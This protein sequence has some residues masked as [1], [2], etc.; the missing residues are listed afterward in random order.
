MPSPS[1]E[2]Q[3]KQQ[4]QENTNII[5]FIFNITN[6]QATATSQTRDHCRSGRIS[7]YLGMI[8]QQLQIEAA[9][10]IS[11]DKCHSFQQVFA[12]SFT[13]NYHYLI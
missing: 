12:V 8:I 5:I 7:W 13:C 4:Q 1:S 6:I 10:I 3:Q 2:Q 11:S 9:S